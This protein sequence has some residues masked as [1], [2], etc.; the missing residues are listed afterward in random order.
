MTQQP[1]MPVH[2]LMPHQP[3]M[4]L[5]HRVLAL[6]V[7]G[8]STVEAVIDAENIFVDHCGILAPEALVELMAQGIAAISGGHGLQSGR[9]SQT[10]YLV[11]IK[12]VQ[13]FVQARAGDHLHIQ[14]RPT[15]EFNGFVIVE[16]EVHCQGRILARGELKIW[17]A[18]GKG[19]D[20]RP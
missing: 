9:Q 11:G 10:G 14:V 7:R 16:G 17:T 5:V 6:D 3:P 1:P 2:G 4:R 12:H 19:E 8:T 15:G 18:T 20:K 13:F